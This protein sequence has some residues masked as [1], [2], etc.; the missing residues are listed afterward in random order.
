MD[1]DKIKTALTLLIKHII[2]MKSRVNGNE[3]LTHNYL[4]IFS[5]PKPP[6]SLQIG[7]EKVRV[8]P[9][10]YQIHYTALIV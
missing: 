7:Y 9:H 3:I 6:E 2:R 8:Q 1:I 5:T 10:I 4:I